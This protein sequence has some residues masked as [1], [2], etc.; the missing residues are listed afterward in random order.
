MASLAAEC[1]DRRRVLRAASIARPVKEL[2]QGRRFGFAPRPAIGFIAVG[3]GVGVTL[4]DLMAWFAWGTRATNGYVIAAYWLAIATAVVCAIRV[5]A[6]IAEYVDTP[7]EERSL[8]RLDLVA[9]IVALIVYG[10][11][12]AIRATSLSAAAAEPAPFLLAIAGLIVLLVD[13]AVAANL[14]SERGWEEL[15][16]EPARERRAPRRRAAAR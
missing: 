13:A 15:D 2:L 1:P 8:A 14:Y 4:T 3:L 10:G 9:A 16:D 12:A 5:L 7:D 6:A 11:S